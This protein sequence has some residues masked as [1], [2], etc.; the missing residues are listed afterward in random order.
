MPV[1]EDDQTTT[2]YIPE[3]DDDPQL[4]ADKDN[5]AGADADLTGTEFNTAYTATDNDGTD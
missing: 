2:L 5:L 3:N 1:F 4:S